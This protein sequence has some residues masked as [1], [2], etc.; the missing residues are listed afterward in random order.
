MSEVE[1][2]Q[3]MDHMTEAGPAMTRRP[4]RWRRPRFGLVRLGSVR[5]RR[6]DPRAGSCLTHGGGPDAQ[7]IADRLVV[8][9][10]AEAHVETFLR[11]LGLSTGSRL[12]PVRT[13]PVESGR[14]PS[15]A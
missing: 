1:D 15:V 9:M 6:H 12:G 11:K 5:S 3:E 10:R 2:A 14:F 7:Q 4:S 8:S 13:W